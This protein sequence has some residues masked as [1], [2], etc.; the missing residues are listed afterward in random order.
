MGRI[1]RL[2]SSLIDSKTEKLR[3]LVLKILYLNIDNN[4]S[5]LFQTL[6][7]VSFTSQ[8]QSKRTKPRSLSRLSLTALTMMSCLS[9]PVGCLSRPVSTS[10]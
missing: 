10:C 1:I 7:H 5:N 8:L 9:T 2:E 6:A 3:I 4:L